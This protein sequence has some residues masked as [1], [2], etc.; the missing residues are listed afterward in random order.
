[1]VL[2]SG[3]FAMIVDQIYKSFINF[4]KSLGYTDANIWRV[5]QNDSPINPPCVILS[6]RP[7]SPDSTNYTE[8]RY[9]PDAP[10]FTHKTSRIATIGMSMDF[11]GPD[12]FEKASSAAVAF[13]DLSYCDFFTPDG[14]V[15][16]EASEPLPLPFVGQD[17]IDCDRFQITCSVNYNPSH[18]Q[19][20]EFATEITPETVRVQNF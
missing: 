15:P 7:G 17:A 16:I 4:A 9:E 13:E 12:A 14:I 8:N 3:G 11:Y 1:M 10:S 18:S 6:I 5:N 19:S 2:C 20:S